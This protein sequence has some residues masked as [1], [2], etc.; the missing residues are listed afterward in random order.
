M[1][2]FI[3]EEYITFPDNTFAEHARP[4]AL[5]AFGLIS[6]ATGFR[7]SLA[8]IKKVSK[9]GINVPKHKSLFRKFQSDTQVGF[10]L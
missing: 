4:S 7:P 3:R 5:E 6:D 10:W 8:V 2:F 1:R 9:K